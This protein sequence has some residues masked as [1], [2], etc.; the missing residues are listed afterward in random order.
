MTIN[1]FN[2]EDSIVFISGGSRGIGFAMAQC[3]AEQGAQVI[4]TG[5]QEDALIEACKSV[6]NTKHKLAYRTCDVGDEALIQSCVDDV[7]AEFGRIDTLI[8][9]AGVNKR[10]PAS[11]YSADEFDQIMHINLRG[12]FLMS[13]IVGKVMKKQGSGNQINIDSLSSHSPLTQILPYAMSKAGVSNMTRGLALEWGPFGV[14]VNAIAPGFILTDL[15]RKLWENK[16]L[17]AWHKATTP[18]QHMGE[19]EDLIGTAIFLASSSASFIT[20]QIIRVDGGATAGTN[21]PIADDFTVTQN[22]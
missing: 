9:S 10:M 15:T 2:V 6:K 11:D 16:N 20:G 17:Q 19:V 12:T 7:V 1:L 21:W 5:R 13:Q 14:R 8:N 18:L 4:I 3:F 22:D